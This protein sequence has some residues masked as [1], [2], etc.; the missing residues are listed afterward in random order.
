MKKIMIVICATI[1]IIVAFAF[2]RH[3]KSGIYGTIDPVDGAKRVWAISG[4]DSIPT[5]PVSGK[6]SI[7]A[8]PGTWRVFVEAVDAGKNASIDNVL[9]VESQFTD[10][11]VIRLP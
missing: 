6:F 7:E 8:K 2:Q 1:I 5:V 10:V 4:R 3:F 9:V 11:G